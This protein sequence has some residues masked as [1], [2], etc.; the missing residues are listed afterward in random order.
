[1]TDEQFKEMMAALNRI[2]ILLV[3]IS[4]ETKEDFPDHLK[5]HRIN[6]FR[7]LLREFAK[8]KGYV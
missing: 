5:Q 3:S 1:M 4:L 8:G 6:Y 2:E 7:G